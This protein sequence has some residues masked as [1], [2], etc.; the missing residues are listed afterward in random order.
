M[1][2]FAHKQGEGG[3]NA[4]R[5]CSPEQVLPSIKNSYTSNL[6]S[7]FGRK[8]LEHVLDVVVDHLGVLA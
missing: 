1:E 7:G 6:L 5:T 2:D 3:V 8:A 4:G